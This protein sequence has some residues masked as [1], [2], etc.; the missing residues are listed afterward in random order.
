MGLAI[1]RIVERLPAHR[2]RILKARFRSAVVDELCRD[3]DTVSE[4]LGSEHRRAED[5]NVQENLVQLANELEDEMLKWLSAHP[6]LDA[7]S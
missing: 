6:D 1:P 5:L 4:A 7:R 2:E 3:Y